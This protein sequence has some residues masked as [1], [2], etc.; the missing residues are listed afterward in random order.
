MHNAQ[1]HSFDNAYQYKYN[2]KEL[3]ETGMYDYGARFY[4]PD[5]GRWGVVD[6]LAEQMRRHSPYNYAFN[7]PIRFIDPDGRRPEHID[8]KSQ[9][10]WDKQKKT[11]QI[12]H[13][14]TV[15]TNILTN[16]AFSNEVE[17]MNKIISNM[18]ILEESSQKYSL[19]PKSG[20]QGGT[21]YDDNSKSIIFD[22]DTTAKLI[23]EITHGVQF[24]NGDIAFNSSTGKMLGQD[25]DDEVSAYKIQ[26]DYQPSSVSVLK[27]TSKIN[28]S[29]DITRTW[30]QGLTKSDGSKPYSLGGA[31]NTGIAPVNINTERDGLVRAYPSLANDAASA[32]STFTL[33]DYPNVHYKK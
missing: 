22:Y 2:G 27:S 25:I 20:E 12:Q 9:A 16:G 19:N 14:S 4:M 23:H 3:Q 18:N 29:K 11:V 6:P 13:A 24:E 30:V 32:P 28:S 1:T 17:N 31:L 8:P 7:N 5:I 21:T 10:E 33:K 26:F 15:A